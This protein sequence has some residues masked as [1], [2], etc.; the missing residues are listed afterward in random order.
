MVLLT[1]LLLRAV[2][3]SAAA[4]V[5][6]SGTP[7]TSTPTR[8]LTR[9]LRPCFL[10]AGGLS[11]A[12]GVSRGRGGALTW[13]W[14]A[15]GTGLPD[16]GVTPY[17][18]LDQPRPLYEEHLWLINHIISLLVMLLL[19]TRSVVQAA[20]IRPCLSDLTHVGGIFVILIRVRHRWMVFRL[21]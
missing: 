13:S 6:V 1:M 18:H 16:V 4:P 8:R 7:P 15:A 20:G 21:K 14:Y 11:L 19:P 5:C 10:W 3:R 9:T 12:L 17:L 2:R